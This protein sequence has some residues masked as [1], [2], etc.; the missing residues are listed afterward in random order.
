MIQPRSLC[1][2]FHREQF[3]AVFAFRWD[4][5]AKDHSN[6][7]ALTSALFLDYGALYEVCRCFAFRVDKQAKTT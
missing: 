2:W 5:P 4:E 1:F 6:A 3:V 7:V